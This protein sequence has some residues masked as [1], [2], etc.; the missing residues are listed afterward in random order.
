MDL[1]DYVPSN[2]WDILGHP[3]KKNVLKYPCC[4]E[5]YPDLTFTL[6]LQRKVRAYH[7]AF[8]PIRIIKPQ[9]KVSSPAFL[10]ILPPPSGS[11]ARQFS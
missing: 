5:E 9:L 7:H 2:E 11:A 1:N 10:I 3:A 8:T 6:A 4:V